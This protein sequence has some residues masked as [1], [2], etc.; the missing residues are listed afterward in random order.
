MVRIRAGVT[1]DTPAFRHFLELGHPAEREL[2]RGQLNGFPLKAL[3]V[4]GSPT[5]PELIETR[6][7]VGKDTDRQFAIRE[8]QGGW[9]PLRKFYFYPEMNRNGYGHEPSIW[10]DWVEIEGPLPQGDPSPFE[11]I[12]EATPVGSNPSDPERA[13]TILHQFAVKAFRERQ[14]NSKFIDS[15]VEVFKNRLVIDNDF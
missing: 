12:Y 8:R 5:N 13:R 9:G 15:L 3:H 7:T 2:G 14:P 6:V 4:T 1:E 10:V 11:T